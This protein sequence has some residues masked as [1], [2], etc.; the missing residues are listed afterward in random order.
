MDKRVKEYLIHCY[1]YYKLD[2][3]IISD[4]EF[5]KLCKDLLD[6]GV[7]H[8]LV[9]KDDLA[10]GTGYSIPEY[11]PEIIKEAEER[12]KNTPQTP[13]A[14]PERAITPETMCTW[15]LLGSYI[16]Y[17]YARQREVQKLLQIEIRRRWSEEIDRPVFERYFEDHRVS[18]ERFGL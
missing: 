11:P 16:D 5:D 1:L 10:A 17:G 6:S 9:S 4:T 2:T 7:E 12:L 8:P 3:A 18:P 13:S 14:A 15:L